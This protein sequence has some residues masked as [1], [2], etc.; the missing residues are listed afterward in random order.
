MKRASTRL[1]LQ[2]TQLT[3]VDPWI[4]PCNLRALLLPLHLP[5]LVKPSV[6][7]KTHMLLAATQRPPWEKKLVEWRSFSY[8]CPLY[9]SKHQAALSTEQ[10]FE[11]KLTEPRPFKGWDVQGLTQLDAVHRRNELPNS[12]VRTRRTRVAKKKK[13]G[14]CFHTREE[15]F[16]SGLT[17]YTAT[18]RQANNHAL[19]HAVSRCESVLRA[20]NTRSR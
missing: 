5:L 14:F 17:L 8:R 2:I 7:S 16:A 9:A 11:P 13:R 3:A 4:E 1:H 12:P 10:H 6:G 19:L 18:R 20:K 15:T